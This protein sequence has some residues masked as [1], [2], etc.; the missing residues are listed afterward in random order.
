MDAE[1]HD[2]VGAEPAAQAPG[3]ELP[4]KRKRKKVKCHEMLVS[5]FGGAAKARDGGGWEYTYDALKLM[6]LTNAALGHGSSAKEGQR[7]EADMDRRTVAAA[8][9]CNSSSQHRVDSDTRT[10]MR[11]CYRTMKTRADPAFD[12]IQSE[13]NS[14]IALGPDVLT[15]NL[16]FD[17]TQLD[18]FHMMGGSMIT[19]TLRTLGHD[20]FGNADFDVV[21]HRSA[22]FPVPC[23]NKIG[24]A[25]YKDND[26]LQGEAFLQETARAATLSILLSGFGPAIA[27]GSVY[28]TF[29]GAYENSGDNKDNMFGLNSLMYILMGTRE[30]WEPVHEELKESGIGNFLNRFFAQENMPLLIKDIK[31]Q[32]REEEETRRQAKLAKIA[33]Q[34]QAPQPVNGI[35]QGVGTESAADGTAGD[36]AAEQPPITGSC[37]DSLLDS[38]REA[39]GAAVGAALAGGAAVA[40]DSGGSGHCLSSSEDDDWQPSSAD[41]DDI[42]E[43]Y[44]GSSSDSDTGESDSEHDSDSQSDSESESESEGAGPVG[45]V[46]KGPVSPH[47]RPPPRPRD[48]PYRL[49]TSGPVPPQ[50]HC[51][52]NRPL[53]LSRCHDR[54]ECLSRYIMGKGYDFDNNPEKYRDY[55]GYCDLDSL[56]SSNPDDR[57]KRAA[58]RAELMKCKCSDLVWNLSRKR[59]T[60]SLWNCVRGRKLREL[61]IW[62]ALRDASSGMPLVRAVSEQA[63]A[64]H[65][66]DV[67]AA[68][69][70]GASMTDCNMIPHLEDF[71]EWISVYTLACDSSQLAKGDHISIARRLESRLFYMR[72]ASIMRE[73]CRP[74]MVFPRS[75]RFEMVTNPLRF[76]PC[77]ATIPEVPEPGPDLH[78]DGDSDSLWQQA[79][80]IDQCVCHRIHNA[81]KRF[82]ST[83]DAGY[84]QT[85]IHVLKWIRC[86]YHFGA[87]QTAVN[88]LLSIATEKELQELHDGTGYYRAVLAAIEEQHGKREGL[89]MQEIKELARLDPEKGL[90]PP[91]TA[92]E[93]RWGSVP[94]SAGELL[95]LFLVVSLGILRRF[96]FGTQ[97]SKVKAACAIVSH[98]GFVPSEHP[99]LKLEAHAQRVWAFFNRTQD[100]LQMA[101]LRF[102]YTMVIRLFLKYAS[103]DHDTGTLAMMGLNSV[104]RNVLLVLSRD[105]WVKIHGARLCTKKLEDGQV[106]NQ[107][108]ANGPGWGR[109]VKSPFKSNGAE[110]VEGPS[111]RLLN[112]NCGDR[113][114]KTL[115]AAADEQTLNATRDLVHTLC[116]LARRNGPA[117][118][119]DVSK[120]VR[121]A[122][123]KLYGD[124]TKVLESKAV[125]MSQMQQ[126]FFFVT[127]DVLEAVESQMQ[128]ELYSLKGILAGMTETE[129]TSFFRYAPAESTQT[130]AQFILRASSWALAH[131]V[132]AKLAM[133]DIIPHMLPQLRNQ[134]ISC[135]LPTYGRA[136]AK[137]GLAEMDKFI[138][139]SNGGGW[140]Q[141]V[142][143]VR[144]L[145]VIEGCSPGEN[146]VDGQQQFKMPLQSQ[147][148]LHVSCM[149]ARYAMNSSKPAEGVFSTSAAMKRTKGTATFVTLAHLTRRLFWAKPKNHALLAKVDA[150]NNIFW[151]ASALGRVRGWHVILT[152]NAVKA[153]LMHANSVEQDL[154]AGIKKGGAWKNTNFVFD[155]RTK[156]FSQ[157]AARSEEERRLNG[158]ISKIAA[159]IGD[160]E[161]EMAKDALR[162]TPARPG[163]MLS[164]QARARTVRKKGQKGPPV[165]AARTRSA[166]GRVPTARPRAAAGR[167]R[168]SR[169]AA[170]RVGPASAGHAGSATGH[171]GGDFADA[172]DDSIRDGGCGGIKETV[173]VVSTRKRRKRRL[174]PS[175]ESDSNGESDGNWSPGQ[176]LRQVSATDR[177]TRARVAASAGT[178]TLASAPAVRESESPEGPTL[179]AASSASDGSG[180]PAVGADNAPAAAVQHQNAFESDDED[181]PLAQRRQR[182]PSSEDC[183]SYAS[184][185]ASEGAA[186][187]SAAEL[188]VAVASL[189]D[190]ASIFGLRGQNGKGGA[191][192]AKPAKLSSEEDSDSSQADETILLRGKPNVWTYA[193]VLA[194]H[195]HFYDESVEDNCPWRFSEV[196]ADKEDKKKF[197]VVRKALKKPRQLK[198]DPSIQFHVEKDD[199]K[200]FYI[201]F[202]NF[203]GGML[204]AVTGF[205]QKLPTSRSKPEA[206][207]N[208]MRFRRVYTSS[209]AQ[210]RTDSMLDR[211]KGHHTYLGESSLAKYVE[212]TGDDE[213]SVTYHIGDCEYKGD[214]RRLIGIVRWLPDTHRAKTV[215]EATPYPCTEVVFVGPRFS[216]KTSA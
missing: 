133:R 174:I 12:L 58:I 191:K 100:L 37:P 141:N 107:W 29:D 209:E 154:P 84:L 79:N 87:L 66:D 214:I 211:I 41:Q 30:S 213:A 22:M 125:K 206:W 53:N 147:P 130:P 142:M 16:S 92:C 6:Y 127:L 56:D 152:K 7:L 80:A 72:I 101:V 64:A 46:S 1:G 205:S 178:K 157:P 180:A 143:D 5:V 194:Y 132:A 63:R 190:E 31:Q 199:E 83:F 176:I 137:E 88:L 18:H 195:N 170:K 94:H 165:S 35:G 27:K 24:K 14:Q 201:M 106:A 135:Y 70:V 109:K 122:R 181:V 171:A 151:A 103:D 75:K 161:A 99:G 210:N 36:D 34:Q 193:F 197:C 42:S 19:F 54:C 186:L 62:P 90:M 96:A 115:G 97:D 173:P 200:H 207:S 116:M 17:G 169:A 104:V 113:V 43:L 129:R 8:M 110:F 105:I 185:A 198:S 61:G 121:K 47:L 89:S 82:V 3:P 68:V 158:M 76:L 11:P 123:P 138:G 21:P 117:L 184:N 52:C 163:E 67:E 69:Q 136:V 167:G 48:A 57:N 71:E 204:V 49:K 78:S 91:R 50:P 112:P 131:A 192:P 162:N 156:K 155:S 189:A 20:A 172:G 179:D 150:D 160:S 175:G 74:R 108:I 23:V 188:A 216:E 111:L 102:L 119:D 40:E 140:G 32:L 126:F 77:M 39:G 203:A 59:W 153:D 98:R 33:A 139:I 60:F 13:V 38:Q 159:R 128:R 55:D 148:A 85:L 215:F 168:A 177:E 145:P 187:A 65:A 118:P 134:D 166:A 86:P 146:S 93:L 164:L 182:Q 114:Q 73:R 149:R 25:V 144:D 2:L 196:V 44:S 81:S 124:D 4:R 10:H 183:V 120:A 15:N 45:E 28:S 9:V 212:Q 95:P 208:T 202:D 51:L 26:G